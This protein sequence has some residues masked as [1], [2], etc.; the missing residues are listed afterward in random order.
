MPE[1]T[2][3]FTG[4]I[5]SPLKGQI[6]YRDDAL[7]GFGLR[8]TPSFK[9]YIAECKV[10][11]T[12]RR[13]TLG[14][15]GSI[16]ADE[17]RTQAAKL[18]H[19][20][21]AKRLPS[22]RSTQAPTLKELLALYLERKTLRPATVLTYRR[23]INGCLQDWLDKPI[24][25][26][27]EE[28]VQT[29][30]RELSKP[31]HMGTLGHDQA[32]TAMHVLS[33][34]LNYAADN[35]Q[36]PDGQ[37]VISLNPVQKLNQ[38]RL[39]YKTNRRELVVSDHQL[40]QWYQAVMLLENT[41]VRD[42]LLLLILTGLRRTEAISLK[43]SDINLGEQ[44][45]TIP[46]EISKNHREHRLPLSDFILA[47][48]SQRKKQG[49]HSQWL[50]PRAESDQYMAYPYDAIQVV[51][52]RAG[53]PFTPHALRRTFCSVA[54]RA[55]VGHHL[56]RKLVNHTQALDVAHKYILIG[57]EGLR[58]PMQEI[59]DRFLGLM[60]CSM[61]DWPSDS[62]RP[63]IARRTA[64]VPTLAEV[65][66]SYIKTKPLRSGAIVFYEKA[67][68]TGLKEWA[69]LPV[70]E[71]TPTMVLAKHRE[72][73]RTRK[74]TYANVPFQVLRLL[75][76]YA[77][78]EYQTPTGRPLIEV[79]PVKQLLLTQ[80]LKQ[81]P[82]K[83]TVIPED[84]LAHWYRAVMTETMPTARDLL[85]FACFTGTT[86]A[87]GMKLRWDDVDFERKII[88]FRPE[89]CQN[90]HGY[91]LPMTE[92]LELLLRQRKCAGNASEFA[93]PGRY[94][95]HMSSSQRATSMVGKK[96][97]HPFEM[98][99]LRRG[100]IAAAA[101]CGI[102]QQLIKRLTNHSLSSDMTDS[103]FRAT[104]DDLRTAMEK[105]S[106]HLIG[107]MNIDLDDWRSDKISAAIG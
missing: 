99:D 33:R 87:Q 102:G 68:W 77:A 10:N 53:C 2:D 90:N 71:I 74:Q 40:A 36:S 23:V 43:W 39:W 103:F 1:I 29:R 22:K 9:S 31:N 49:G 35:L 81:S 16:S 30:H 107:L 73:S 46:A 45:L 76:Y 11:G 88:R 4:D 86:R 27:D 19:K 14:R 85:L 6:I 64:K 58:E 55:G 32:N 63:K 38:N 15:H 98:N 57:V 61:A 7:T 34:L 24:T 42:Y 65:L 3:H 95:G 47:L 92:F 93:F 67:I 94:G 104:D 12:A 28:M 59:T 91:T 50:F 82:V 54:A 72:L 75:L 105:I 44:T 13:V 17:A 51:A 79:N 83:Q 78:E 97:G 52:T 26:I 5:K 106:A 37:P 25:M 41:I 84:K 62:K 48:L 18:I 21:S 20:M 70:T 89:V 100:F 101:N 60:G 66:D 80:S 69:H 8:V 96:I 56:I